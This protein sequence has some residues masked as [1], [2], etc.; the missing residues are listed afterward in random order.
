MKLIHLSDLHIGKKVNGFSMLQDQSY[1]L[2]QILEK[3][4]EEPHID[5]VILAGDIYDK[6]VPS[7]EA[8]QL[9]D[10]FLS[11]LATRSF[12]TMII[13]GNH[14]SAE[15]IAFGSQLFSKNNIYIG[16]PYN[17][18]VEPIILE[19][20]FGP[21]H[22]YLLPFIKPTHVRAV[23]P[24]AEIISYSDAIA[25]AISH[26]PIEKKDNVRNVMITHQFV[27]GSTPCESEELAIGGSDA[28]ATSVFDDF[29][30]VALGHIHGAQ[31]VGRDTIRY[32]GT[33]LKYSFSECAHTKSM[34]IVELNAK[35]NI[36]IRT[37]PLSPLLDLIEL[38]GTYE[39]LTARSFYIDMNVNNYMHI[40][41]TDEWDI[42][43]ALGKLRTIYPNIM[44][45]DYDNA[46][47][48]SHVDMSLP[49]NVDH[50]SPMELFG[51][52]YALQNADAT[53]I[54]EQITY[55]QELMEEIWED[56]L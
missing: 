38:R 16:R 8:V 21:V 44:K 50:Q 11:E 6:P 45:L 47:T 32:S 46:R 23:Y 53:M 27:A 15:R 40:T 13:S 43:D 22:F 14:D 54:P 52:F 31:R 33:P 35:D 51:E 17:G 26:M 12:N 1:I 30:Y 55:L 19:D 41:L 39:E 36:Q 29:D 9:F 10:H 37:L 20:A 28:I 24:D 7:A 42:P 48:R 5:V 4:D 25:T 56:E 3:I 34:T 18:T 2:N 49:T